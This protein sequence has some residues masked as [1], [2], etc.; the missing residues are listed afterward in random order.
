MNHQ[1]SRRQSGFTLLEL[2]LALG[3]VAMLSLTLYMGL[4]VT[5]R[6][7]ERAFA[8]VAPVRT[9]LLAADLVRQDLESVLPC[10]QLL[11]G[12]FIGTSQN[13]ADI[14]DFYCLGSDVGWHAAPVAQ[15]GLT[16][17]QGGDVPWSE[18]PRHVVLY[19]DTTAQPPSLI[20]SVTRNLLAPTVP[21]PDDEI[22]CR[23]VK[24]F[25]VRYFDGT[26]WQ[27]SWDSTTLGDI[28]PQAVQLTFEA[29]IDDQPKPGQQPI[30]YK[31]TRVFPLACATPPNSSDTGSTPGS[32]Q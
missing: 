14:L 9:V 32:A 4:T 29:V 24:S 3:M 13:G 8:A 27:D 2:I 25:T 15:Q 22:L 26:D 17:A 10:K 21:P 11:A 23:N 16:P 7:K 30:V 28:L 18:G 12:P 20:R 1:R 5:V 19:L 31:V 6:A